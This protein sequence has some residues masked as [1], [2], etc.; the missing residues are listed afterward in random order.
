MNINQSAAKG[1]TF[2]KVISSKL[3]WI[4]SFSIL[5]SIAAQ[6]TIPAKPVPYTLQTMIVLL[7]GAVLGARN[8]A[9]SQLIYLSLGAIGLPVFAQVPDGAVGLARLLGPTGGYLFA[10]P[11]AAFIIGHL[12]QLD[13]S[14][15]VI[16]ASM[17]LGEMIILLVG[18][19]YL[20]AFFIKNFSASLQSGA[21]IFSV[22]TVIKVFTAASIYLGLKK[23]KSEK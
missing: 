22:W 15:V 10:F 18:V 5:T 8:G 12:I 3:V 23:I 9:Y 19:F 13:K 7:S 1:L 2:Q 14:Y 21:V 16:I 17:F 4:F 20:D 6:I 11:I